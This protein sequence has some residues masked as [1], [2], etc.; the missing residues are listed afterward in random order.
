[1]S[2][3]V[4]TRET[5]DSYSSH[6]AQSGHAQIRE[7]GTLISTSRVTD[8]EKFCCSGEVETITEER[9]NGRD[10]AVATQIHNRLGAAEVLK[11]LD[12][13]VAP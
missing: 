8:G 13:D 9:L 11:G 5:L 2:S 7:I 1:M 4:S 12:F 3:S 10:A 6:P